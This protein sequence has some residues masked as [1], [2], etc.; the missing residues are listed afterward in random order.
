MSKKNNYQ[1][2]VVLG[3]G[4]LGKNITSYFKKKYRRVNLIDREICDLLDLKKLSILFQSIPPSSTFVIPAALTR[5]A[6]NDSG[7]Y[8]KNIKIIE[9]FLKVI[10]SSAKHVIFFSTVDVYGL[11]PI[12]PISELNSVNPNDFYAKA[13][14]DSEI[15]LK[16]ES[17]IKRFNLTILRLCGVYGK[18]DASKSTINRL[19]SSAIVDRRINIT[20]N[21]DI[22][23]DFILV[24]DISQIIEKIVDN[25]I[26][27]TFNVATGQS[28]TI[29]SIAKRIISALNFKVD[30][31]VQNKIVGDRVLK[32]QFDTSYL[33]NKFED[34]KMTSLDDG[35]VDYINNYLTH[36]MKNN[37]ED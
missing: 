3:G 5:L 31:N 1:S 23:R 32:L 24:N 35:L 37:N 20:S 28:H 11:D 7:S 14:L 26:I 15:I 4:F 17:D 10:P 9:N 21:P 19:V 25:E 33:T 13:K 34:F 30:I 22:E 8:D 16:K 36:E 6:S 18:G 12:L 2:I 27:G 29:F